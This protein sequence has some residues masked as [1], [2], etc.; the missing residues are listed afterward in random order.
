MR[1]QPLAGSSVA[2]DGSISIVLDTALTEDLVR[3]GYARE[4]VNRVQRARKDR[5][6]AL[7]DRIVLR[8]DGADELLRAA[9]EHR[10]YIMGET[11]CTTFERAVISERDAPVQAEIDGM[12]IQFALTKAVYHG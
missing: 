8:F 6:F 11:L 2:T 1:Q 4:I 5:G 10:S 12:A 3:G 7:S 9:D